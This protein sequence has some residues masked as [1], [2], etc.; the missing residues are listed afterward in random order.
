[1]TNCRSPLSP[2]SPDLR[3][4]TFAE[5][6]LLCEEGRGSTNQLFCV[7]QGQCCLHC[8]VDDGIP[9]ACGTFTEAE[10]EMINAPTT[11]P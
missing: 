6:D 9:D 10:E 3:Y 5:H 8:R 2:T 1:M 7:V 11:A 4:A